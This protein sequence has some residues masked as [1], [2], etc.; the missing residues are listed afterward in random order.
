M[1][2]SLCF[3]LAACAHAAPPPAAPDYRPLATLP[4]PPR[5]ALYADCLAAAAGAHAY[6]R[7]A[8]ADTDLLLFTCE[9]A[10]AEAFYTAL[11]GVAPEVAQAGRTL[12]TTAPVRHDLFGVDYCT[13]DGAHYA[14]VIT[15]NVGPFLH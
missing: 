9:G 7:A 5:A 2:L 8:D 1:R 6:A 15:L 4:A 3:A 10:P 13:T 12:R 14:C 11:A